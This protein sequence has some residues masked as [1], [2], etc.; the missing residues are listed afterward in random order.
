MVNYLVPI[1]S[2]LLSGYSPLYLHLN[3]RGQGGWWS[4][5]MQARTNEDAVGINRNMMYVT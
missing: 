2:P 1:A 3:V 5:R 4:N